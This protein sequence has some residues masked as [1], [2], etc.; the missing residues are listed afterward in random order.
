VRSATA[1][2]RA[3]VAVLAALCALSTP[4]A[5]VPRAGEFDPG[6]AAWAPIDAISPF[7][8][9]TAARP[10]AWSTA[11]GD[12]NADGRP[13]FAVADR[14]GRGSAGFDYS[15]RFSVSGLPTQSVTFASSDAAL[16]I[17]LRDV[18][19]DQDLDVVVSTVLSPAAVRIWLND[20]SGVFS[21]TARRDI[22]TE[23]RNWPSA[24]ADEDR[25]A[26]VLANVPPRQ[27][28]Q[29]VLAVQELFSSSRSH[30]SLTTSADARPTTFADR[31]VP[32][33][34]PPVVF[35]LVHL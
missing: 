7:K 20:G 22:P 5:A 19:H 23:W 33:R 1:S 12:L 35:A 29:S 6:W 11:I 16:S 2:R 27:S 28:G 9:G 3:I 21:E 26:S 34:A 17:S 24:S 13:D 8:L 14:L 32:S 10:F 18:D 25:D 15:V 30:S 31:C 4:G